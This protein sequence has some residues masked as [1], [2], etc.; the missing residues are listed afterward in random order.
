M[1]KGKGKR[2]K[3]KGKIRFSDYFK[4][5]SKGERISIVPDASVRSAF[6]RRVR[7][8]SGVVLESRGKFKVVEV[9]DGAR[10]KKFIIHP[11][12]LRRI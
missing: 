11:V 8:K 3:E 4:N 5:L 2:I 1:T 10:A 12:H 6:P 9:M 7:G